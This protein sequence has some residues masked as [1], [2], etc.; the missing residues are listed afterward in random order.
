MLA[1]LNALLAARCHAAAAAGHSP[2]GGAGSP[3]GW[4]LRVLFMPSV[5][6]GSWHQLSRESVGV[7][8]SRELV[9]ASDKMP[10]GCEWPLAY[11]A[12][13]NVREGCT[14][15]PR[16]ITGSRALKLLKMS[17]CLE[18]APGMSGLNRTGP[19]I[20]D[21]PGLSKRRRRSWGAS[22][23]PGE[24]GTGPG[25]SDR[26][27][28]VDDAFSGDRADLQYL[29]D[30]SPFSDGLSPAT[31]AAAARARAGASLVCAAPPRDPAAA[32]RSTHADPS[33]FLSRNPG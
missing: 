27:Q 8:N 20:P 10:A 13:R 30:R 3:A 9:V 23:S 17:K 15:R 16:K 2:G 26:V 18:Y 6:V 11:S 24:S 22:G 28:A 4:V 33:G 25:E 19:S 7:P 1:S 12:E 32:S 21:S 29:S 14:A 5:G 31:V